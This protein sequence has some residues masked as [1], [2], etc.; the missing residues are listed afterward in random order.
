MDS[1]VPSVDNNGAHV[2]VRPCLSWQN[3]AQ[4]NTVD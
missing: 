4:V 3:M 1:S 2:V